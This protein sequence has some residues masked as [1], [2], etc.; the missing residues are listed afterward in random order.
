MGKV[1]A[2]SPSDPYNLDNKHAMPPGGSDMYGHY[3]NYYSQSHMIGQGHHV[4][5]TSSASE[6]GTVQVQTNGG[7]I[8]H[9]TKALIKAESQSEFSDLDSS[10][11][12]GDRSAVCTTESDEE[13]RT[14]KRRK[15]STSTGS[16][17]IPSNEH[18]PEQ[19]VP[20]GHNTSNG[21]ITFYST[22]S[23]AGS[24]AAAT[25]GYYA[26]HGYYGQ[27]AEPIHTGSGY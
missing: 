1:Q 21:N 9:P 16:S 19:T 25:Y 6:Y 13:M 11:N 24:D 2:S 23:Y 15:V 22:P 10:W 14:S 8:G 26:S 17:P 4:T 5:P 12:G 27:Q 3:A 20:Y 18:S 7:L